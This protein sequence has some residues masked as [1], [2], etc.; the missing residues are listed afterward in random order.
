[1]F[2]FNLDN[3]ADSFGRVCETNQIVQIVMSQS[4]QPCCDG[5]RLLNIA[6][7][8]LKKIKKFNNYTNKTKQNIPDKFGE[9]NRLQL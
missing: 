8:N 7:K 1:M 5:H 9:T 6:R 2:V 3:D 4:Q